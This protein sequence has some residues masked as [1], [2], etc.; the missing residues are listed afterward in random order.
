MVLLASAM[1]VPVNNHA[2]SVQGDDLVPSPEIG[3]THLS[4]A[5]RIAREQGVDSAFVALLLRT[6][7]TEFND[8]F[9]RINVTNYA[10]KTDYTHNHNELG[11]RKVRVFVEEHDS[12]LVRVDSLY[13]VSPDVIASLLW[14]E[15]KH[16]TVLGKYHVPSVYL[17]ILL[18][19]EPEF[20]VQNTGAVMTS[21]GLDST[22]LDSVYAVV[23]RKAARKV[24]WAAEQLK[25]LSAIERRGTMN[26]VQLYGSWAGA[27]GMTQFIPSSYLSWAVDGDGNGIIDLNDLDDAIYSVANYLKSNGWGESLSQQRAAVYHYNNSQSYVD[28]VLTLARKARVRL[29]APL[30]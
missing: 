11:I 9:V 25:A 26:T 13:G 10:Q 14:V 18:S 22:K 7:Q 3:L 20:L 8:R 23:E 1:V 19:C 15:S 4:R 17:S 24:L 29:D 21:M 16:G 6:S 28:A 2:L 30:R 12:I 5:A 27:F